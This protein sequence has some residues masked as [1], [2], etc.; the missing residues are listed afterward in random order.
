MNLRTSLIAIGAIVALVAPAAANARAIVNQKGD[1][2]SAS[3]HG[4][5]ALVYATN[6][7]SENG[8]RFSGK[9]QGQGGTLQVN[10][11]GV[12]YT[13][14]FGTSPIVTPGYSYSPGPINPS[15]YVDPNECADTGSNC[16][17][18]SSA[19]TG[20]KTATSSLLSLRT[21]QRPARLTD[22]RPNNA[23]PPSIA[24]LRRHQPTSKCRHRVVSTAMTEETIWRL[25]LFRCR[26]R[27][28]GAHRPV[29]VKAPVH[30]QVRWQ[31]EPRT[32][33]HART[34]PDT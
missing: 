25:V 24:T 18:D 8:H 32:D 33:G 29:D 34:S 9:T 16:T 6:F 15:A 13:A 21:H 31:V 5:H 27:V 10:Q 12:I 1:T 2:Y 14:P 30:W 22:R 20:A 26:L 7:V 23:P 4:S 28:L 3:K 17:D 19:R 11:P